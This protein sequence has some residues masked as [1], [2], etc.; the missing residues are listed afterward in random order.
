VRSAQELVRQ[1]AK[2]DDLETEYGGSSVDQV[3]DRAASGGA[4]RN[5]IKDVAR[6]RVRPGAERVEGAGRGGRRRRGR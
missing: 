6:A 1:R 4:G 3:G 5:Y 2:G